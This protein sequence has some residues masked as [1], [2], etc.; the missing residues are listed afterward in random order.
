[1]QDIV[2][3][4]MPAGTIRQQNFMNKGDLKR[5]GA[6][7]RYVGALFNNEYALMLVEAGSFV[8]R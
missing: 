7:L 4:A 8:R 3:A 6:D 1:M 2:A 5:G